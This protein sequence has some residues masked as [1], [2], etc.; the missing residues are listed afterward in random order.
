MGE[1]QV[2]V[3]KE[4]KVP[5]KEET[6]K[7]ENKKEAITKEI[8]Q[9]AAKEKNAAEKLKAEKEAVDAKEVK[10]KE[11]AQD[12]SKDQKQKESPKVKKLETQLKHTED[13]VQKAAKDVQKTKSEI[14]K[15]N[16]R[17]QI[18]ALAGKVESQNKALGVAQK[19]VE[20]VKDDLKQAKTGESRQQG[21]S[22]EE[23]VEKANGDVGGIKAKIVALNVKKAAASSSE[24][25]S[26]DGQLARDKKI[27]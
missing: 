15:S 7:E 20:K 1:L 2:I 14:T 12:G 27:L 3:T 24:K 16:D 9:V 21:A 17:A 8:A 13:V 23:K 11:K 22:N 19:S 10:A 25:A 26:L 18:I 4:I 5:A 6:K